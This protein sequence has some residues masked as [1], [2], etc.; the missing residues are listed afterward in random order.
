MT[1]HL[2][3]KDPLARAVVQALQT[4]DVPTLK[5]LL[6]EHPDLAS[7]RIDRHDRGAESRTLLHIAT[8]WPGHYPN[9][10]MVVAELVQAGADVNRRFVGSHNETPLHWAASSNDVA[11]LDALIEAGA[12]IESG[13][14]VIGGGSPLADARGFGQWDAARRLVERGARTT[15]TDAATLGLM[16]R[17]EAHFRNGGTPTADAI[18]RAFWGACHGGQR[19]VAEYLL[20]RGADI[21]W[22]GYGGSTPLDIARR[23]DAARLVGHAAADDLI[24]WLGARGAQSANQQRRG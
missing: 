5:R 17:V 22:I 14:G 10:P 16:D 19:R 11:V 3:A 24:R 1:L 7:A 2:D 18:T 4:G 8:D 23:E 13:G 6:A 20:D 21:N 9:G 15:L 12:D